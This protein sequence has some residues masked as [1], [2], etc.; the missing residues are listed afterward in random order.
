MFSL[1]LCDAP[2]ATDSKPRVM[3][4]GRCLL[5]G[6]FGEVL[7]PCYVNWRLK[8]FLKMFSQGWPGGVVVKFAVCRFASRVRTWYWLSS[9]AVVA[10]HI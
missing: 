1:L 5:S 3:G 4:G 9:H 6:Q 8:D 10:S 7:C 2:S